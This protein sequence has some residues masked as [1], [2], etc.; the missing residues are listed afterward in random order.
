MQNS[1]A[2]APKNKTPPPNLN[3]PTLNY[4]NKY[5]RG[6]F[7]FKGV[8]GP[9]AARVEWHKWAAVPAEVSRS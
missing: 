4:L 1:G 9:A 6:L 2:N 3:T 5:N 7:T 8:A